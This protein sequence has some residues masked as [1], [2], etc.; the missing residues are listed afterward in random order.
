MRDFLAVIGSNRHLASGTLVVDFKKPF[1]YLAETQERTRS[2]RDEN[3]VSSE[4]WTQGESDSRQGPIPRYLQAA[5]RG[6][7]AGALGATR[8]Q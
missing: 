7:S 4:M 6:Y 2:A 1:S 3:F 5:L 8:R